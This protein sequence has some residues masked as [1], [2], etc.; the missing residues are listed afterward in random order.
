MAR[1]LEAT[2]ALFEKVWAGRVELAADKEPAHLF[3][4]WSYA[5]YNQLVG[6]GFGRS[7]VRPKGHYGTLF[8]AIALHTDSDAPGGLGD[9]IVH[10]DTHRLVDRRMYT[11]GHMSTTWLAE[12]LAEY[13]ARTRIDEGGQAEPGIVGGKAIALF[14]DGKGRSDAS[15]S[16]AR[17]KGLS[18]VLRAAEGPIV[19]PVVRAEPAEFYSG[20]VLGHYTASWVLVH[21]LLH[22]D[23]PA[24]TQGFLEF[25]ALD[26][27]GKGDADAFFR[28]VG[29]NESELD[30]LLRDHIEHMRVR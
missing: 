17:L 6:G 20:D 1:L 25:L 14:T 11:A 5:D 13:F 9:T 21:W 4:F 16:K 23:D 8:D 3:L 2:N 18:R 7:L 27:Q 10:E 29:V 30:A 28:T 12:G 22:A 19:P 15:E 24:R 26:R